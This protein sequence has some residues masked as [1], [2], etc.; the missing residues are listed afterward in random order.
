MTDL[1]YTF[2]AL[3]VGVALFSATIWWYRQDVAYAKEQRRRLTKAALETAA[4]Q[5]RK[6]W[7]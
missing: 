7:Y 5:E 2:L 1:Q 3:I 6:E 4:K